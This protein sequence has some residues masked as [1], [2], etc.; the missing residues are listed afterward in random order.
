LAEHEKESRSIFQTGTDADLPAGFSNGYDKYVN[1]RE[2]AGG[3]NGVLFACDD[4]VL[5][6]RVAI[7][8]LHPDQDN[9]DRERRRLLRE[10][11]ITSQ[12]QHPNTVPVYELGRS[13]DGRLYFSMKKIEGEDLFRIL[14]RIARGDQQTKREY[15]LDRLLGV[16]VQASNALAYAHAR[17]VIHRDVKPENILVGQFGESYLMDWGVAKVWGM[18]N[19]EIDETPTAD[20]YERLTITGKRPGTPLY[21]SPEQIAPNALVDERSDIFSMG[22]VLY[23]LLAQ[24]EPFR[25]RNVE[26][27]F[28]NIRTHNPPPPSRVA[29]HMAVPALLDEVCLKAIEKK[30]GDR[31]QTMMLM[32]NE[33]REFRERA[34][35]GNSG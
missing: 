8:M 5:G 34:M 15:S 24:R 10:A 33:I 13:D 16:L 19:D 4:T 22:V 12:L 27:T 14:V 21:M 29:Q 6:R 3:G 7:K 20:L 31:Y 17:G 18:A 23:E 26:E 25:G 30:P 2:I 32:V 35:L 28:D 1:F 11:R 9:F